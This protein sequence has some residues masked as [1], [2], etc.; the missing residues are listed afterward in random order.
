M[1][2]TSELANWSHPSSVASGTLRACS[3]TSESMPSEWA[4]GDGDAGLKSH[5]QSRPPHWSSKSMS[6]GMSFVN[7]RTV[8]LLPSCEPGWK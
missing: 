1:R 8:R 6:T 4:V 5:I 2:A 3:S 7:R